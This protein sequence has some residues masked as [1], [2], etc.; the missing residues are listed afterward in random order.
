MVAQ[1]VLTIQRAKAAKLSMFTFEGVEIRL[2][3]T[4]NAFITMNPG[5]AGRSELPDNL[6]VTP[7]TDCVLQA[8]LVML[9]W[10]QIAPQVPSKHFWALECCC[11]LSVLIL[12]QLK[13]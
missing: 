2:V 11:C 12:V 10:C 13:C 1:Q 7:A 4:C 6:K 9:E 8:H 5:Y 3:P